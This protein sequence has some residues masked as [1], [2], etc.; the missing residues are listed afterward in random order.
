M[1][2]FKLLFLFSTFF[3]LS[4]YSNAET[5]ESYALKC[6]QAIGLTVKDF[7]CDEGTLVPTEHLTPSTATYPNGTC[8][9]PNV[10]NGKC[11]KGSRFQVL[12]NTPSAFAVAHCRKQGLGAGQ[13]GD[14]AVIQHNKNNGA[15]CFYQGALNGNHNGNVKAPKNGVG[16][17]AFWMTPGEIANSNFT[18]VSCHDNGPIIRNPYLSQIKKDDP[19]G[20]DNRLPGALDT[21]F[22]SVQPYYFVGDD[23]ASWKAYTVEVSGNMCLGCHRIGVS[24]KGTGGTG[25]DFVSLATGSPAQSSK[26][27]NSIDSPLWML[28]GQTGTNATHISA[29]TQLKNCA[30]RFNAVS[31]PNGPDCAIK[32]F[33]GKRASGV[34]GNYTA[35]WGKSTSNEIQ[36][37]AWTYQDYRNKYDQLWTSGWRLFS[38][39]PFVVNG[40]VRYNA[41]WRPST[42]GEIQV[43][44]WTYA[45]YRAKYDELW[46]QGWRLKILQPYVLNG[47]VRYTAVWRPSTESEVQVYGWSYA[48]FR[49]KYDELWPQGWRLKMIQPYVVNGVV[50]Y[51]AVW[52]P[53][54]SNEVQV[55]GWTYAD[56]RAKY[57]ELWPLGWRLTFLQ[58]YL[59]A[60][61]VRYT[62]VWRPSTSSEIQVYGWSYDD[63]RAK[64]DELWSQGW[65]LKILQTY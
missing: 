43:Y 17:P 32:Q 46:P 56:Y 15:T 44:G 34:P 26:N 62:A 42:Q 13:Y 14:I 21:N 27:A 23:F 7:V 50:Y 65:R 6:D 53:S 60:G 10:L 9:R 57:D 54:T 12:A 45:D 33:T 39:Q 59:V 16:A 8:D 35:V 31:Q 58:P 24:N 47:V 22:N 48:D 37:Y 5:L 3:L 36:V 1:K 40:V 28:P 20:K 51:T 49:A 11:D 52:R 61:Q 55:Y 63:Y 18:C 41:V 38:L 29:A 25:R 4:M 2:I 64:Y 30:L 19:V